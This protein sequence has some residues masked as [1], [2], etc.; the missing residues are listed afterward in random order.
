M[1][2][3]YD[4]G[5]TYDWNYAHAPALTD[6]ERTEARRRWR[7]WPGTWRCCGWPLSAPLSV[8]AGPLLNRDWLRYY[9]E[10][11]FEWLTYKTVR[12]RAH[13]CYGPPNLQP[14]QA[15]SLDGTPNDVPASVDWTGSWAVSFGM[16]SQAPDVWQQDVRSARRDLAPACALSVSVVATPAPTAT[17]Q[18]V[19]EDYSTCAAMAVGNGANQIELNLSCPNVSSCEGQLYRQADAVRAVVDRVRERIG[20]TPLL[21]KLGLLQDATTIDRLLESVAETTQA[22]VMVNCIAKRVRC[23]STWMFEGAV[24]GIAGAAIHL[25]AVRQVEQFRARLD[26]MGLDLQLVG[27][28]GVS[29]VAHVQRFLDAGASCVQLATAIMREPD[30]ALRLRNEAGA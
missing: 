2:G 10:L 23:G 1:L 14:V 22:L 28:G 17:W 21:L 19:A 13:P 11:G 24:R 3:R 18:Q 30:I 27:S 7:A 29:E 9:A 26:R 25:A 12:Q 16:P 5:Q 4:V 6:E 8:A 15:D 20:Q